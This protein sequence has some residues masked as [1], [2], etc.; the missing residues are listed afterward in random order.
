[1][2][3]VVLVEQLGVSMLVEVL[4]E[5]AEAAEAA[6]M[7]QQLWELEEVAEA[8]VEVAL[9]AHCSSPVDRILSN[10]I[11]VEVRGVRKVL[12]LQ[13]EAMAPKPMEAQAGVDLVRNTGTEVPAEAAEPRQLLH[14]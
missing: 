2:E 7:Q 5:A 14:R 4:G 12:V 9:Q 13:M 8:E 1:M 11:L 3:T 6:A 10:I